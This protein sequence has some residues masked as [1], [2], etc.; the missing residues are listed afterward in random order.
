MAENMKAPGNFFLTVD[1]NLSDPSSTAR[2][3][4]AW[5]QQFEFYML[6]TEKNIKEDEIQVA[7]LLTILGAQ[8]QEEFERYKFYRREQKPE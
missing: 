2:N 5:L 3:W 4:A 1:E 7:T 8:G 6:A